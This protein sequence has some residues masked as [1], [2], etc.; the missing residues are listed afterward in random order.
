MENL[1]AN[2]DL[3][4]KFCVLFLVLF[5]L[6]ACT[7]NVSTIT[8]T[9]VTTD[10]PIPTH[11]AT[12]TTS[13]TASFTPTPS[14]TLVP[15]SDFIKGAW[16]VDWGLGE[17][18]GTRDGNVVLKD[19]IRPL[20]AN[21][22]ALEVPCAMNVK[23]P[24]NIQCNI[25]NSLSDLTIK[26]TT[27]AAHSLGFRVALFPFV[28]DVTGVPDN[29]SAN[30][31]Y[32]TD[33]KSWSLYFEAYTDQL[34]HYAEIAEQNNID[35]LII[36]GE[37]TGAERQEKYWRSMISEVRTVYQGPITY[38]TWCD[39][40]KRVN[41]WDA[42]DYIGVNFYCFPLSSSQNPTHKEV[43]RQYLAFLDMVK[44]GT[45]PWNKPV[46]FTEIG[47]ESID[48]VA[49][50]VPFGFSPARLDVQ[51]Q[52]LLV[53]AFFDALKEFG[54][55]DGWLKGLFWYNF[56]SNPLLGGMGDIN[57]TPHN[58]PA[59]SYLRAFYTGQL[60]TDLPTLVPHVEE[61][62]IASSYWFFRNSYENGTRTMAGLSKQTIIPDPLGERGDVVLTRDLGHWDGLQLSVFPNV[63][64]RDFDFLELYLYSPVAE[65]N[66]QIRFDSDSG[67]FIPRWLYIRSYIDHEP[68]LDNHWH[69]IQIPLHVLFPL[70]RADIPGKV[71][72]IN[73]VHMWP[74]QP[75][76]FDFYVDDIRLIRIK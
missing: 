4:R 69:R 11:T 75:D 21:W 2:T 35:L 24:D 17:G 46:I 53:Q 32:G 31:N 72:S 7:P 22:I 39:N 38:E 42:V 29:W 43:K 20:G 23:S 5:S 76:P 25:D 16:F 33:D 70:D 19:I 27:E 52:G 61:N 65:P 9:P 66:L 60:I 12:P 13:P 74:G 1:M 49:Q 50:I 8:L 62:G 67:F 71:S 34:L 15:E 30:L 68:L 40:F 58:K 36:G 48:G 51:E 41:W 28:L 59:E 10:T 26:T 73:L 45:S 3:F 63:D 64:L 37:Q 47:Y 44:R 18:V 54:Y 57:F 56:T 14:P 55:E 6:S